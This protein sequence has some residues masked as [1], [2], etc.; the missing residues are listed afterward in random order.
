MCTRP[1]SAADHNGDDAP[2]VPRWVGP[3]SSA[4]DEGDHDVGGVAVEVL[5]SS[6]VD[7]GGSGVC[8]A[9]GDLD[10]SKRDA[11]VEGG[12]DERG[13]QHVWVHAAEL[14]AF[15][16]RPN[17]SVGGSPV[18]ALAVTA[19][20]DR[21][22]VTLTDGEV[23]CPGGA[24]YERHGGGLVA[25]AH[26]LQCAMAAL[27]AEVV[28]VGGAGLADAQPVQPEQLGERGVVPVVLLGIEA[29]HAKL[30]AIQPAGVRCVD[31]GSA[32]VLGW[33]RADASVDVRESVEAIDRRESTVDRRR[34]EP[35]VLHPGAEQLDV[36]TARLH[37]GDAVVGSPL[38]EAAQVVA[39]HLERP[40]AVAGKERD[41]SKLRLIDVEL[42]PGLPDGCRCG[43]DGG[44]GWAS[45]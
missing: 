1:F 37:D 35:A 24:W 6:V 25:L 43:L 14:G 39:V 16:D 34:G 15:A 42:E 38:E 36:G 7:G 8:V 30:G 2:E 32:D 40:A 12:H 5:A 4:G 21:P 41:R 31:V 17:P 22:L 11:G 19:P 10:V 18:E 26:D 20:Q 23:D 45:L 27:D 13:S 29:E 44:H 28:D 9:G 33:V 3:G